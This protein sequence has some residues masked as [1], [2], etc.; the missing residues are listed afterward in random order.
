MNKTPD[1]RKRLQKVR[2]GLEGHA[3]RRAGLGTALRLLRRAGIA[4]LFLLALGIGGVGALTLTQSGSGTLAR[5]LSYALSAPGREVTLSGVTGAWSGHL[6][7]A[8]VRIAD[9]AGTWLQLQGVAL[10][11]SPTRL[12]AGRLSASRV[13]ADAVELMRLPQAEASGSNSPGGFS[14]P[15]DMNLGDIDFPDIQLSEAVAGAPARLRASGSL[16]AQHSPVTLRTDLRLARAD[17]G[18]GSVEAS[19]NY[20]D[21]RLSIAANGSEPSGGLVASLLR[22]PERPALAFKA[23]GDGPLSDWHGQAS[24]TAD[25][26]PLAS[27]SA[28]YGQTNGGRR[29]TFNGNGAFEAFLPQSVRALASGTTSFDVAGSLPAKGGLSLD[30]ASLRSGSVEANAAGAIDPSGNSDFHADLAALDQTVTISVPGGLDLSL[31]RADVKVSG[32]A[33]HASLA[34]EAELSALDTP[35]ASL[36]AVRV[37]LSSADFDVGKR[38]GTVGVALSADGASS[39]DPWIEPLLTG[40]IQGKAKL[41]VSPGSVAIRMADL[42]SAATRLSVTGT[43]DP[44]AGTLALDVSADIAS[45]ALPEK[46][47][48][49]V[50]QRSAV[51]AS[52]RRSADG[53]FSADEVKLASAGLTADGSAQIGGGNVKVRLEGTLADLSRI[54]PKAAGS[55]RFNLSAE[56][57]AAASRFTAHLAS[58]SITV[59]GRSIKGLELDATGTADRASPAADVKLSGSVDGKPLAGSASLQ[60]ANGSR[61]LRNLVV[62]LGND[63]IA[64]DL[65]LNADFVPA[66]TLEVDAPEIA[67]LAAL[68]LQDASG[69]LNGSIVFSSDEAAPTVKLKATAG[70]IAHANLELRNAT[71]DATV[72]DY[73]SAPAVEGTVSARTLRSGKTTIADVQASFT[74]DGDATRF[75]ANAVANGVPASAAGRLTMA[76]GAVAIMLES[77]A[78]SPRGTQIRLAHPSTIMV[79]DGS[80]RFDG[81]DL[82]A[83]GGHVVLSGTAGAT[84]DLDAKLASLPASLADS[85]AAGLGASGTVTGTVAISGKPAAPKLAYEL[86]WRQAGLARTRAA[87]LPGVTVAAKGALDNGRLSLDAAI[88]DAGGLDIKGGGTVAVASGSA[89]DL[90]FSGRLPFS[91]LSAALAARGL[92]MDGQGSMKVAVKGN[93]ARPAITGVLQVK[94]ARIADAA[95]GVAMKNVAAD[96]ALGDQVATVRTLTADFVA[97]GSLTAKGTV[98]IDPARGF[99]ADLTIKI[100]KGRYADGRL[101]AT[102]LDGSATLKGP[103]LATPVLSGKI[104]LARTVVTVPD[105]VPASIAKLDVKH[106][107][108]PAAVL[109]QAKAMKP[110]ASGGSG[111]GLRFD[112]QVNAPRQIFVSGR[113]LYVELGGSTRLTGTLSS[114]VAIGQFTVRQGRLDL[115]GRRLAIDSGTLGFAGSLV[116]ELNLTSTTTVDTTTV[117]VTITG[118]ATD[119]K[120]SFSSSPAL[121]EDEVLARLVFGKAMSSLSPLQIAQLADS[122][123]TLAGAGGTS[124]L[125]SSLRS[126]AGIDDLSVTTD[127]ATGESTLAVGKY[128]NDRT[129]VTLEK[130]TKSG[131][132]KATINLDIGRGLKLRGEAGQDG[133]TRGGLYYEKDY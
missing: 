42:G 8:S 56:G 80:A 87:G 2:E 61:A 73:I 117:T 15:V 92:S 102:T 46:L 58:D 33:G 65:T 81:L 78:A 20:R 45:A 120:F 82:A 3:R 130:G 74:R 76:G 7:I 11:W 21:G 124:S 126:A 104:D 109:K 60:T 72:Y 16:D 63:R 47:R 71:I 35:Q 52:V 64:G 77:A 68:A 119:P 107:N 123:A 95:S 85:F 25:G 132:A 5:F 57:P 131:S 112:L 91:F 4:F 83:S 101:V 110:P 17:D 14:L 9:P 59:A 44:A 30:R 116:P 69:S 90:A 1:H 19:I 66:G 49:A 53:A 32:P 84:L 43:L 27:V 67:P 98:G 41:A 86:D 114:P 89:L 99:P 18:A 55:A 28:T 34:A 70:Q 50:G 22:I 133:E 39:P 10:D 122:A 127:A 75:S 100:D 121:P 94:D 108:A 129:Y 88:R 31:S 118:E 13:H 128:V 51:T 113:G 125:L 6:R 97:G 93:P 12:I 111:S 36:N 115:L 106:R 26:A 96:I 79:K 38:A 29:F 103:L 23:A 48:P 105:R 62:T 24:I 40:A 37:S 54:E